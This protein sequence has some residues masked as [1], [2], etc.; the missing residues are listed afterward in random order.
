MNINFT[1][2][3]YRKKS[4]DNISKLYTSGVSYIK[5]CEEFVMEKYGFDDVIF[6]TSCTHS[7]EMMALILDLKEGDEV[8][9]PSYTFVST[10]NAFVKF[11]IN[12]KCVDSCNDNPNIEP[13][14]ILKNITEKTKAVVVV[15]YGGVSCEMEEI[16]KIC[17]DNHLYLLE[18]AAQ[19]IHSFYNNNVVGKTGILS[20]FSFHS[21]K[22]INCS[23][24]GMLVI[25]DK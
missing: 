6:T 1:V 20:A 2:P 24:G 22:N 19:S 14:E 3:T 13:S 25:N 11:G 10:A 7:L 23:E 17:E 16:K 8:L 5:K 9:I 18:D 4:K 15:H 12:V 21:T